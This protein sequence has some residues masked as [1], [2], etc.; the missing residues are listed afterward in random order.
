M[1][2]D[3][4]SGTPRFSNETDKSELFD[5]T[6]MMPSQWVARFQRRELTGEQRLALAVLE[7]AIAC[8]SRKMAAGGM[9][10]R[11][12]ARVMQEAWEWVESDNASCVYSF[13]GICRALSIDPAWLRAGIRRKYPR[14]IEDEHAAELSQAC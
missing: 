4:S 2:F 6:L 8:C 12:K 11:A 9:S 14:P 7:E 1:E 10:F 13:V 5:S 3:I